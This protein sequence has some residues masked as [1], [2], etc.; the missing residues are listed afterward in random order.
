MMKGDVIIGADQ[1]KQYD[2]LLAGKRVALITNTTGMSS[3]F[4]PTVDLLQE[5]YQLTQLFAPEHGIR[6]EVQAGEAVS[7]YKDKKTNIWVTSL[8]G[9]DREVPDETTKNY[10]VLIYDIQ[11]IG[12]R[13][14][15]YLATLLGCMKSCAKHQKQLIVLDRPNPIGGEKVEGNI[16]RKNK[17]SFVGCFSMPQRYGLT[18]GEFAK[19]VNREENIGCD[20]Q[21][22]PLRN[23]KR[24]MYYD[25][26]GLPYILPSPN[27]PTL[28][29]QILYNGTCLFEGTS[30]SEGRGTT[31]PFEIVG[32]PW[33]DGD[34]LADVMNK[35]QLASVHFR[36]LYFT[37]TF[38]KHQGSLCGGVQI[39]IKDKKEV[40]AV[41]LGLYLLEET[42]KMCQEENFFNDFFESL[43][44][45]T[46]T[47]L[48]NRG[49]RNLS[50]AW[51]NESAQFL[52]NQ[53]K[54]HLYGPL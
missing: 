4:R 8:Y 17:T 34:L 21:I 52:K 23:Y 18:V 22:I 2:H 14:Y 38:S 37:P 51:K 45:I 47:E 25:E 36:G 46:P 29:T 5:N 40:D 43:A 27:I 7:T 54:Y 41:E 9:K 53:S 15:T 49:A 39:H 42:R 24:G 50:D 3:K 20:L 33:I 32:A 10:D 12:S 26:T 28:D 19:M 6:G 30:L 31:K 1:I 16:L 35:K 48:E 11:D 44:G 13:Y